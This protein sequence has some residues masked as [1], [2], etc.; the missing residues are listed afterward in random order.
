MD[1]RIITISYSLFNNKGT[2][3][4]LLGSGIS[5]SSGIPTGWDIVIDIIN[6]IAILRK[7]K[8]KPTPE[9]WFIKTFGEEPDYSNLLEKLTKTKEER[10]NLLRPYFEPNDNEI[11]ERLKKPTIAHKQIA[12]LVKKGYIKVI[13]TTNFDR[14]I[15]NALKEIGIEPVVISNPN[16]I[17]NTIPL[18]HSKITIIKINGDYLDTSFLNIKSELIKYDKRVEDL[19]KYIFE[20]F[21]LI[22]SGWSAK[23]DLALVNI[24]KSANKFRFTNYF[25]FINKAKQELINLSNY[26]MG[27]TIEIKNAD[28]FFSELLE[29][30]DALEN[31]LTNHPL[32]PK[33]ALARLKKYIVRDEYIISLNDLIRNETE[34][35]YER[36]NS[37]SFPN[38]NEKEIKKKIDFYL[39]QIDTLC[40]LLMNGVYW[41]SE[42]HDEIWIKTLV[43]LATPTEKKTSYRVWSN[44]EYFPAM[45]LFYSIGLTCMLKNKFSLLL[46]IISIEIMTRYEPQNILLVTNIWQVVERDHLRQALGNK[47]HVPMS[48]LLYHSLRKHFGFYIPNEKEYE[49]LFDYFEYLM[50]L[51]YTKVFNEGWAPIGRFGYRLRNSRNSFIY[52]KLEELKNKREESELIIS[53]LFTNYTEFEE[54]N[55][56]FN[57]YFKEVYF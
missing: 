35:V 38:P 23:W 6:Q 9:E 47:N 45:T 37:V 11:E 56:K 1:D 13:I 25:T 26:R 18:I 7:E 51:I 24:L 27:Q 12:Q 32:T 48:E 3:A 52:K 20:N 31:N 33:I 28:S 2:F 14:L 29:N 21:G 57:E 53:G 30:I 46:K 41:G 40:N 42:M 8:C 4:L 15:E 19:L 44:I 50:A 34:N 39:S 17:E 22:S 49:N 5:R 54:V 55:K 16:H 43:R 10:L 36:I